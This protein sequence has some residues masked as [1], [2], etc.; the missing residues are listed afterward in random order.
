M[1]ATTSKQYGEQFLAQFDELKKK[2][3]SHNNYQEFFTSLNTYYCEIFNVDHV[4]QAVPQDHTNL[5]N[6]FLT[7]KVK[8]SSDTKSMDRTFHRQVI[9]DEDYIR[10][11]DKAIVRMIDDNLP[12]TFFTKEEIGT[13]LAT[14]P[15]K[16][17]QAI[18]AN[19]K[20]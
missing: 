6:V 14:I 9:K 1:G 8:Y 15:K 2:H 18:L 19:K 16:R 17:R 12:T 7:I 13:Y 20:N 11:L 3:L 10:S 5:I 4:I